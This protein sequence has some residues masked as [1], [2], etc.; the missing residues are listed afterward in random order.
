MLIETREIKPV[1]LRN[2]IVIDGLPS[3]GLANAIASECMIETV[4]LEPVAVLDSDKFQSLSTIYNQKPY[5]P[6]RIH[7]NEGLKLAVFISEIVFEQS[8]YRAIGKTMLAWAKEH[9]CSLILSSAGM[10]VEDLERTEGAE[11]VA[12][13]STA[14]AV[15]KIQEAGIKTLQ[16][17]AITGIPAV[18]LNEGRFSNF[19]VIVLLVKVL[20]DAPD[21]RA[22][23]LLA[24]AI[25]KFAPSCH[26]D[27]NSLMVEAEKVEKRLKSIQKEA[28]PL[29]ESMYA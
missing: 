20:K 10:P 19:D 18:L 21:F 26:C 13:G 6:A 11:I 7:A 25:A 4:G 5:F 22:A 1:K 3:T 2:G 16:H 29:R 24:E 14:N 8:L 28:K 23:A 9:E 15:K 12:V 27:I 17:G